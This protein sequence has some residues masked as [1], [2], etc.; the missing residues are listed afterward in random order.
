M[1]KGMRV[2]GGEGEEGRRGGGRIILPM[3]TAAQC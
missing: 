1:E 2:G 3:H